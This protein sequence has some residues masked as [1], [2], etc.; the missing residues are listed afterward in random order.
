MPHPCQ[1][2]AQLALPLG[3][4]EP[5]P[6]QIDAW[7]VQQWRMRPHLQRWYP[8][9]AALLADPAAAPRWRSCGRQALLARQRRRN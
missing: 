4:V 5:A 1:P 7:V 6:Q 9:P 2:T 3:L 8:S